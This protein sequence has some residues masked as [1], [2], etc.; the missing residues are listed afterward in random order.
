MVS[1]E[2]IRVNLHISPYFSCFSER[3]YYQLNKFK[4]SFVTDNTVS[5]PAL[6]FLAI[7]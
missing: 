1:S 7:F 5:E 3:R 2:D 6:I 4:S